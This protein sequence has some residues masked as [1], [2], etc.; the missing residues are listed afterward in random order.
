MLPSENKKSIFSPLALGALAAAGTFLARRWARQ[1]SYQFDFKDQVVLI[2]GASRGLGLVL[3]R[4]L[5]RKGAKL[6]LCARSERELEEAAFQLQ[7]F[8]GRVVVFPCDVTK[9]EQVDRTVQKA[10]HHFGRIDV[11]INNAGAIQVGPWEAMGLGDYERGL[12]THFWG[13]LYLMLALLPHF[14]KKGAGRIVNISS[15]GGKISLPHLLPY[16]ASKFALTGLSEGLAAELRKENIFVTTVC[17]GLMRTGSPPN[18]H[19]KGQHQK[20]YTWFT[21]SDSLPGLSMNAER[22]A[23]RIL[24]ACQRGQP[25]LILGLPAKIGVRAHA[26]FP[27]LSIG[28]LSGLSRCLPEF[29]GE[30]GVERRG[31]ESRTPLSSSVLTLLTE[32]AARKNNQYRTAT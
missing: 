20:E 31:E 10:L 18:A 11:L 4:Q 13:P 30:K 12:K 1:R 8:T 24:I 19:F 17:P 27:N 21:I 15:I 22:A 14:R 3:A 23:A 32:K 26:F 5:A 6:I 29:A 25:E 7:P 9:K 2:T 16:S 28:I